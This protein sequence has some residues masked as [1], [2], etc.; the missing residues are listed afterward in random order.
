MHISRTPSLDELPTPS[1]LRR[2]S[3]LAAVGAALIAVCVVLPAEYGADPTGAGSVLG[4]TDMGEI[5][6]QLAAEAEADRQS[7]LLEEAFGLIVG[8]AHAQEAAWRDAV[9]FTLAPGESAE[10][11]MDMTK[12]QSVFYR[13]TAAGGVVN[14]DL[15]GHGGSNSETY[16]KGRGSSGAEGGIIA[17]FDGSHGWFFRNRDKVPVTV[18][19]QVRGEY[20]ALKQQG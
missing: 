5:K 6:S 2:S 11:K 10:W 13:M 7:S 18:T 8:K 12:G 4:L 19:L 16:E 9:S 14:Y 15:H 3:I 20:G 1:Q 17:S